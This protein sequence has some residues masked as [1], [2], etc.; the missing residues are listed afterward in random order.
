[1]GAD[2]E[3]GSHSQR[4]SKAL[5]W[6]LSPP[7]EQPQRE[8]VTGFLCTSSPVI[9]M[10]PFA[11]DVAEEDEVTG[12]CQTGN[13]KCPVLRIKCSRQALPH[14]GRSLCSSDPHDRLSREAL[15]LP[16]STV[17]HCLSP[18]QCLPTLTTHGS[19][20]LKRPWFL[21]HL[22]H[23]PTL[24]KASADRK[25]AASLQ[26]GVINREGPLEGGGG[27][28][29]GEEREGAAGMLP[30]MHRFPGPE[31]PGRSRV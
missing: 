26:C 15:P 10:S 2:S 11:R 25:N 14:Q 8:K 23:L 6:A 1:M 18:H 19:S 9:C 13:T 20:G 3:S 16:L 24:G 12:G 22:I 29:D 5:V 30:G 28:S 31:G 17:P 4:H 27:N 21:P 7:K